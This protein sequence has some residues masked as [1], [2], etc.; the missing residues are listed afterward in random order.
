MLAKR[1]FFSNPTS[2]FTD[3][4]IA[5]LVRD[6]ITGS[7]DNAWMMLREVLKIKKAVLPA[8][9]MDAASKFQGGAFVANNP[10]MNL[11]A[12]HIGMGS[13]FY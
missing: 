7:E 5:D 12:E 1:R 8:S 3:D 11:G 10:N 13:N 4:E 6:M 9:P 2:Q